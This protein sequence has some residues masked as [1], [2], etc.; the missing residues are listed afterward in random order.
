MSV[1]EIISILTSTTE[2]PDIESSLT[3]LLYT[4]DGSQSELIKLKIKKLVALGEVVRKNDDIILVDFLC[5]QSNVSSFVESLSVDESEEEFQRHKNRLITLIAKNQNIQTKYSNRSFYNN[6]MLGI[7]GLLVIGLSF[8]YQNGLMNSAI[9]SMSYILLIGVSL[10]ILLLFVA[11]EVYIMLTKK[12][13]VIEEF[14]M[15]SCEYSTTDD[16]NTNLTKFIN[17]LDESLTNAIMIMR[18]SDDKRNEIVKGILHDYNNMNY[19]N[20]RKYQIT[21]YKLKE[22]RNN[23]HFLK[24][25]FLIIS[26]IGLLAG[27]N[28]RGYDQSLGNNVFTIPKDMLIGGT[29]II[30]ISY[31]T[32]F[33]LHR[34]QNMIRKKYNWDKLYWN[35]KAIQK[36]N[37]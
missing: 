37:E 28:L 25:G 24:Y 32:V 3:S 27:L 14:E 35:V 19:V 4:E 10:C 11:Y 5:K 34:K 18:Y 8:V 23:L 15:M 13:L 6:I 26:I 22:T 9:T 17:T 2:Y 31:F 30:G 33:L 1:E 21:D 16:V 36:E 29:V 20:M 7:M 12:T